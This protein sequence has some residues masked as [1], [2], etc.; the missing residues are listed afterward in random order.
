MRSLVLT[1]LFCASLIGCSHKERIV[2]V[3]VKPVLVERPAKPV[4]TPLDESLH[5]C[6]LYNLDI[7]MENVIELMTAVKLRDGVIDAYEAQCK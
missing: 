7:V 4:L 6:T 3:P 2:Y 5:I 1:I